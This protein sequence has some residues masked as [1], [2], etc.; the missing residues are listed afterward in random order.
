M[1]GVLCVCVCVCVCGVCSVS[2]ICPLLL[3]ASSVCCPLIMFVHCAA[4][5]SGSGATAVGG[6]SGKRHFLVCGRAFLCQPLVQKY[7]PNILV[8]C[9]I[10][11]TQK[12]RNGGM[13]SP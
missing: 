11:T 5:L 2:C 12:S 8:L 3:Q 1:C 6:Q 4:I 10:E 7:R 13:A 9:S